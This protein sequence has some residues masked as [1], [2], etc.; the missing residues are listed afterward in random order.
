[1]GSST[2]SCSGNSTWR[3]GRTL[4]ARTGASPPGRRLSTIEPAAGPGPRACRCPA[5]PPVRRPVPTAPARRAGRPHAPAGPGA[6]AGPDRPAPRPRRGPT[7]RTERTASGAWPSTT[8]ITGQRGRI[9]RQP[10]QELPGQKG[11]V[12]GQHHGRAGPAFGPQPPGAGRQ[13]HQRPGARRVLQHRGQPATPGPHL[14]DRRRDL[15]QEAS[16]AVGERLSC[17]I[18][19]QRPLVLAESPAGATCQQQS[20]GTHGC[21]SAPPS[22]QDPRLKCRSGGRCVLDAAGQPVQRDGP[23]RRG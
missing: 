7:G 23:D 6:L 11:Q 4:T 19:H 21:H 15:R 2:A 16:G 1:M 8:G 9:G 12:G 3:P 5:G 20:G 10:P 14:Q 22:P 13:R 17:A 18:E